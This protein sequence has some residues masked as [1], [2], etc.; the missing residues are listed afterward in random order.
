MDLGTGQAGAAFE[1]LVTIVARL[2]APDGCPWDRE[3]THAT[4]RP[5]LLEESAEV[6]EAIELRD[7][8]LLREELGDLTLQPVLHAQIAAEAGDFTIAEVLDEISDKLIRRHPHVFGAEVAETSDQVLTNWDAI[9]RAEKA[10][11]GITVTSALDEPPAALPALA[12]AL[13]ISKK[14]AKV[15]FEWPDF[16]G[17]LDKLKE[18][19]GELED[20]LRDETPER[21]AEEL[22]DLLFTVVNVARWKGI[23]PEMAL[24]DQVRRFRTR[25]L[26]MER[27]AARR[28]L[29]LNTLT[30]SQWDELWNAAK[31]DSEPEDSAHV[32]TNH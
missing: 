3:Q 7:M 12:Q 24:R 2:R 5:Y 27:A 21:A 31:I 15:G 20:A 13:K 18:E 22:G 16:E 19:V 11:R 30:P 1:R 4:L 9:K 6:L 23:N 26:H 8:A 14:A 10:A 25:F 32:D 29:D 28:G 17:V